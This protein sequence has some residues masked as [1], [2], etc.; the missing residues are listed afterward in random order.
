M[1]T[2]HNHIHW[3]QT[4]IFKTAISVWQSHTLALAT[5]PLILWCFNFFRFKI[6]MVFK[7]IALQYEPRHEKTCFC[8]MRTT[9]AQI[10]DCPFVVHCLDSIIH[11][12]SIFERSSLYLASIAVQTCLGVPWSQIPKTGFLVTRLKAMY[13]IKYCNDLKFSDKQVWENRIDIDQTAPTAVWTRSTLFAHP[14]CIF[15]TMVKQYCSNFRII[16]TI[17]GVSDTCIF[18]FLR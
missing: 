12:V 17:S 9:K 7:S 6:N 2:W 1:L 15:S 5:N 16:T 13:I 18:E 10:T 4:A 11:L 8:H 3:E 14:I